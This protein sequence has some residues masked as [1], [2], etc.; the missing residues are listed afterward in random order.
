M[1]LIIG[2]LLGLGIVLVVSN[3][4]RLDIENRRAEIEVM[5]LVGA[6]NGFTRRPF[7][8]TG[9][10]YGL[11][12]A[13]LALILVAVGKVLLMKPVAR[14]AVLY[15]SEFRLHGFP[16]STGA[17]VFLLAVALAWMGSW[18]A[19]SRHIRAIEPL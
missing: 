13:L 4:I 18:I 10:W 14:V 12:G 9:I 8:Y 5:K 1:V 3:T 2:A 17:L 6:S 15:G 7:L 16:L 19:V 11:G